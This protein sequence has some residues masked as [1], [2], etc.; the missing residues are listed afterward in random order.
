MPMD[1]FIKTLV[2]TTEDGD[3]APIS[4]SDGGKLKVDRI[5]SLIGSLDMIID[6]NER[7]LFLLESIAE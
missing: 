5:G 4:V 2:G 7:I 3:Y 1:H 6:Q